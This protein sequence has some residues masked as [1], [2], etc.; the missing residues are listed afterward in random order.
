M[1]TRFG[2]DIF[3]FSLWQQGPKMSLEVCDFG[4]NGLNNTT[5]TVTS[6]DFFLNS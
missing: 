2:H 3:P 6:M 5:V 4:L 1:Y